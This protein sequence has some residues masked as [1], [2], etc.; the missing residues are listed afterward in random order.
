MASK[1]K[2]ALEQGALFLV[3]AEDPAV[4]WARE[5]GA[6]V[7]GLDEA[8]RGP[9]AG[10][11]VAACVV[12]PSPLPDCLLPLNDSKKLDEA[13][14]DA[15]APIIEREAVAFAVVAAEAAQIDASNILRASLQAMVDAHA[16]C[17]AQLGRPIPCVLL[18]GNQ[19]A[20]FGQH[21]QQRTLIG[22]DALSRPI[23]AASIL[24][25][26]ARD[27]RMIAEH[28]TYPA[29]GF[30][31]HKGY[32]TPAHL[33]ALAEHG[34]TPIHRMSFAPVRAAAEAKAAALTTTTMTT[35]FP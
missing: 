20:P 11:V 33:K 27:R 5:A 3:D 16:A 24:A 35:T 21:V 8:G 14:R 32:P 23:M 28:D 13:A 12:L 9:L 30:A 29:Y 2:T 26:V 6:L 31:G 10:P 34:P 4:V 25:K 1:K 19:K 18:D 22:G 17:E 7:G 15:L